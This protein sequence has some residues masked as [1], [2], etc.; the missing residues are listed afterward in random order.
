MWMI[1][2]PAAAESVRGSTLQLELAAGEVRLLKV[3]QSGVDL[4][5]RMK[6]GQQEV[7][8]SHPLGH[9]G[10]E[11]LLLGP[12]TAATTV[13][14]S[15]EVI[16]GKP[17]ETLQ[18]SSTSLK[19]DDPAVSVYR[20]LTE[21]GRQ[22]HLRT[23]DSLA[24]ALALYSGADSQVLPTE[25][26][27]YPQYLA[28]RVEFFRFDLQEAKQR[29][30]AMPVSACTMPDYCYKADLLLQE[31]RFAQDDHGL[32]S[33]E[34]VRL[35][36]DLVQGERREQYKADLALLLVNLGISEVIL[37]D[38]ETSLPLLEAALALANELQSNLLRGEALNGLATWYVRSDQRSF[39]QVAD[40]LQQAADLLALTANERAYVYVAGNLAISYMQVGELQLAQKALL[41]VLPIAERSQDA[42]L[43]RIIY[44]NL[45]TVYRQAGDRNPAEYYFRLSME[46]D[47]I[48]GR[49]DRRHVAMSSLGSMLRERGD[50]AGAI[51]M[52]EQAYAF[53]RGSQQDDGQQTMMALQEMALDQF[54][55]GNHAQA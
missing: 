25:W 29:L 8:I 37:G 7:V 47:G 27:R 16:D 36:S 28:A 30:E 48:S 54:A 13:A 51:G 24:T 14:L 46:M 12:Y 35:R 6:D 33:E 53:F 55:L 2:A 19:A 45:A 43:R 52:H 38:R 49:D 50:I 41:D 15:A 3:E 22:F 23:A 10:P 26:Q 32:V 42:S 4:Q 20:A 34:L 31:I 17:L 40:Y 5:I 11:L 18:Y 39:T 9:T 21:A 44:G 1:V